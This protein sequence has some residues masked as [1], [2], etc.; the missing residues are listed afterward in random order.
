MKNLSII[1]L[2]LIA[3]ISALNCHAGDNKAAEALAQKS[4]CLACHGINNKIL[5]PAYVDVANKYHGDKSAEA[6]LIT[7]VKAGGSGVWGTFAMPPNSP[8]V[9]DADIKTLVQWVLSLK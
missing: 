6:K 2:M 7:K 5:G 8:N 9:S 4:G 1:S 3:S